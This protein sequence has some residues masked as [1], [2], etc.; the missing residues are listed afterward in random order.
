MSQIHVGYMGMHSKLHPETK[1]LN[2]IWKDKG[3]EHSAQSC[4]SVLHFFRDELKIFG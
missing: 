1:I 2:D 3:S 4:K